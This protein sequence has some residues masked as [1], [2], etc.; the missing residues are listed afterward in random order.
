MICTGFR[1]DVNQSILRDICF[2]VLIIS[3]TKK[4]L[5]H[6]ERKQW[7]LWS[8]LKAQPG[9]ASSSLIFVL[10]IWWYCRAP[11]FLNQRSGKK[12]KIQYIMFWDIVYFSLHA[13]YNALWMPLVVLAGAAHVKMLSGWNSRR[14]DMQLSSVLTTLCCMYTQLI[15]FPFEVLFMTFKAPD[16]GLSSSA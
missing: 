10:G 9:L 3:L 13:L 15:H 8:I 7:H 14:H 12:S 11:L 16:R 4:K 2:S 6:I 1:F 5:Q